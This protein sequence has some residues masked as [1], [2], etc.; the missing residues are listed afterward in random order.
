MKE[1]VGR[2]IGVEDHQHVEAVEFQ[3]GAPWAQ[4]HTFIVLVICIVAIILSVLYYRHS[5][6]NS[7]SRFKH[8]GVV[9]RALGLVAMFLIVARPSLQVTVAETLKPL[10]VMLFDGSDSMNLPAAQSRETADSSAERP[11]RI[12]HIRRTLAENKTT[13]RELADRYRVKA[14][15]AGDQ[16][17]LNALAFESDATDQENRNIVDVE[18]LASQMIAKSDVTALGTSIDEIRRRHRGR[19]LNRVV[20]FSD[21]DI[22]SGRP[23]LATA[24]EADVAID[25]VGVGPRE[26]VDASVALYADLVIKK[27]EQRNVR[28]DIKQT[29]LD[30]QSVDIQLFVRPLAGTQSELDGIAM[31]IGQAQTVVLGDNDVSIEIPYTPTEAGRIRLE[32]RLTSSSP[33]AYVENNIDVRDVVVRDESVKVLFVEHSPTWEWRFIKEVFHQDRLVGRD[34]FRTYLHSAD[35][36]VRRTN[37]MFLTS[38]DQSRA[39]FFANDVIFVSDVPSNL[40][41]TQFQDRLDEYVREFGGGL[42][43]IAGPNYGTKELM[44]TR[45]ADMLPVVLDESQ[46][47]RRGSFN[48]QMTR[49]ASGYDFMALADESDKNKEAWQALGPLPWYQPVVRLHPQGEALA[50]HPT[51]R[52]VDGSSPQPIVAVRRYGKGEVIYIGFNEMWRLRRIYGE[53]H[54]RRFWGQLMYR[55]GLSHALGS[56]KRF[57]VAT[58]RDQF[59]VGNQVSIQIE[60][61]DDEFRPLREKSIVGRLIAPNAQGD[62][63]ETTVTFLPTDVPAEYEATLS[64]FVEGTNRLVVKDPVSQDETEIVLDVEPRSVERRSVIRDIKIQQELAAQTGGRS[65]ELDQFSELSR[66]IQHTPV[67]DRAYKHVPL[68]NSW[69]V[70][71]LALALFLS[72]WVFRKIADLA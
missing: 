69:L 65:L 8:L 31:P 62:Q 44:R 60:A 53:E 61:Y 9:T 70:L 6:Q 59:Q 57:K 22:N 17:R 7:Q 27:D 13:L 30:D 48:L 36:D 66:D 63:T 46:P 58:D 54:Y 5:S 26:I 47:I 20:V 2:M 32:A 15:T 1:F 3:W 50:V 18:R 23:L 33:D 12:E 11:S 14:Y 49:E 42:V 35:F 40:L 19:L 45:I 51:D 21:F 52:C 16:G 24:N 55:L 41:S 10:M 25:T 67:V 4:G 72:E 43:V 38:M 37:P 68:W 28:V 39:E 29:G 71:I 56:Q 64:L 34:G